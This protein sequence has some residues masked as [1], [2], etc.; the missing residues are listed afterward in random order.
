LIILFNGCESQSEHDARIAKEARA[1][2]LAELKTQQEDEKREKAAKEKDSTLFRAGISQEGD[3]IT[4][5]TNKTRYF[6][7]NLSKKINKQM[8]QFSEEMERSIEV[9]ENYIHIDINKTGNFLDK[10]HQK[11][12]NFAN[13]IDALSKSL[14]HNKTQMQEYK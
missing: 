10:W 9:D 6:F 1:E 11:M 8:E 13:E 4:I 5:D 2:L 3:T 7:Q 14:E 12:Q